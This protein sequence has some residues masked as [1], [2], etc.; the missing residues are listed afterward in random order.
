MG[1]VGRRNISIRVI[2]QSTNQMNG[3]KS[4]SPG[5]LRDARDCVRD[6]HTKSPARRGLRDGRRG[7]VNVHFSRFFSEYL[8]NGAL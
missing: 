5:F 8:E 4:C 1:A 6:Q 7:G 3:N 2:A